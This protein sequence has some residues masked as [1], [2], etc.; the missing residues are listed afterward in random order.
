MNEQYEL[1]SIITVSKNAEAT[2]SKTIESIIAQTYKNFESVFIDGASNDNTNAIIDS[3]K[4]IYDGKNIGFTHVSEKDDGIYYAMNKGIRK[5][6]GKWVIFLN[7]NDCFYN[8][9]VLENVFANR[10]YD[11]NIKCIYGDS[12]NKLDD[13]CF[14]R[15]A[16]P[17]ETIFYRVPFMHQS[18]FAQKD[19]L[20]KYFFDTDL[21][22]IAEYDQFLRMYL[23]NIRF[24]H[25]DE[26]ISVFN[27]DGIS[28]KKNVEIA[29]GHEKLLKKYGVAEKYRL[30]RWL[31]NS[32]VIVLKSNP[33]FY[34]A[35][36]S[37]KRAKT[38]F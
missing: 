19:I 13:S 14:I 28:Q 26:I 27:L 37:L 32:F 9:R 5:A 36:I 35:Y 21:S 10:K 15:K 7:A 3:F 29:M 34:K 2:I 22:I 8:S 33:I 6:H 1:I 20:E 11:G 18:L 4:E 38:L 31:R 24:E 23:D 12:V 17:M 16:L 25:I 30:R